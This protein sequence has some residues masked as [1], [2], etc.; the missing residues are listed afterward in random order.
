[1]NYN[2]QLITIELID[3]STSFHRRNEPVLGVGGDGVSVV[4]RVQ[5]LF[6]YPCAYYYAHTLKRREICFVSRVTTCPL[7]IG[8]HLV[9]MPAT[10]EGK[11]LKY[12]A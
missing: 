9:F 2:G 1:M 8:C 12:D 11:P 6:I 10:L 3:Y 7:V 4:P 5:F